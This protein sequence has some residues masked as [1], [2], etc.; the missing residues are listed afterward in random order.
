MSIHACTL[1]LFLLLLPCLLPYLFDSVRPAQ[2]VCLFAMLFPSSF[3]C[4]TQ[5]LLCSLSVAIRTPRR[6][7]SAPFSVLFLAFWGRE[8]GRGRGCGQ[9]GAISRRPK[10]ESRPSKSTRTTVSCV[11]T[12]VPSLA[13]TKVYYYGPTYLLY[14]LPKFFLMPA[15]V[16]RIVASQ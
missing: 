13:K 9:R 6:P 11:S 10:K 4:D 1:C 5:T 3:P 12:H 7:I 15:T 2:R 8:R 14:V 16:C